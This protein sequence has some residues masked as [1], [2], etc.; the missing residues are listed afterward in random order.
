MFYLHSLDTYLIVPCLISRIIICCLVSMQ[1]CTQVLL[2]SK[3]IDTARKHNQYENEEIL[4]RGYYKIQPPH[5]HA[6][7]FILGHETS[8]TF[9]STT[10]SSRAGRCLWVYGGKSWLPSEFTSFFPMQGRAGVSRSKRCWF[11]VMKALSCSRKK[12]LVLCGQLLSL[13]WSSVA[14]GTSSWPKNTTNFST[15]WTAH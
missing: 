1:R 14:H 10:N 8:I 3:R 11:L 6:L 12:Y 2:S 13:S 15:C 7:S 9:L 4:L 5:M